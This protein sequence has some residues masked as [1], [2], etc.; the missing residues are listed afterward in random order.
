MPIAI[1]LISICTLASIGL[2]FFE[3]MSTGI[4]LFTGYFVIATILSIFKDKRYSL[5]RA[6]F[7]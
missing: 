6:A 2:I 5:R 3:E 1:G 4:L 7:G